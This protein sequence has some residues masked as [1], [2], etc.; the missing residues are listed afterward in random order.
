MFVCVGVC[1]FGCSDVFEC[2]YVWVFVCVDV[3]MCGC[4]DVWGML[5]WVVV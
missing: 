3:C 5:G 4:F 1:V 2:S